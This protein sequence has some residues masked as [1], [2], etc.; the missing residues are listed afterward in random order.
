[1][2]IMIIIIAIGAD[3]LS[4]RQA[5]GSGVGASSDDVSNTCAQ[6]EQRLSVGRS[7]TREDGEGQR[8][9]ERGEVPREALELTVVLV[10]LLLA[11]LST[12]SKS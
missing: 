3:G 4:E 8:G 9:R 6:I 7:V 12:V 5:R 10:M 2:I 1:M 11:V